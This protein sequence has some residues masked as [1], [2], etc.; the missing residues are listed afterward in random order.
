VLERL[1]TQV[2]NTP[3]LI[4]EYGIGTANDTERAAYLTAGLDITHAAI[5]RGIDIRGF[6]H[7]T[8]IDN[9]EWLHGYDLQFGIISRDRVV[10]PSAQILRAETTSSR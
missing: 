6:F 9:Y 4:A 5:Q 8:A 10:K 1:H 7:W 2:P 3:L